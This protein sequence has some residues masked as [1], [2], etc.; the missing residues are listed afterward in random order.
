MAVIVA[1]SL[2]GKKFQAN[3]QQ[4]LNIYKA[5]ASG[6]LNVSREE[7]PYHYWSHFIISGITFNDFK[8]LVTG[9]Q[10]YDIF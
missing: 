9:G 8:K 6:A 3:P 5:W 4:I 1:K 7:R 2:F 10:N